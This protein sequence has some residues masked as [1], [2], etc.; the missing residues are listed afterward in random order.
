MW[1]IR[2]GLR[3]WRSTRPNS[4]ESGTGSLAFGWSR[5]AKRRSRLAASLIQNVFTFLRH[6][7][8]VLP[9][10]DAL[11]TVRANGFYTRI[12]RNIRS[13]HRSVSPGI[14]N[15]LAG[16]PWSGLRG[17]SKEEHWRRLAC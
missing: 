12:L 6:H 2:H 14:D 16:N 9:N 5:T 4:A 10:K 3:R 15:L 13:Y 11:R 1:L 17:P 7:P 8:R